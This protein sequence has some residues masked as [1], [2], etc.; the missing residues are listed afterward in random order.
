MFLLAYK[1]IR[2]VAGFLNTFYQAFSKVFFGVF[3]VS[4]TLG[5]NQ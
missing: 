5:M 2:E 1:T 4:Q 3:N